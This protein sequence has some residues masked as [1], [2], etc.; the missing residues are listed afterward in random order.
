[1][2][3]E[4]IRFFTMVTVWLKTI[5]F[6]QLLAVKWKQQMALGVYTVYIL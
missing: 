6:I 5:V 3:N 2:D 4:S 1:M